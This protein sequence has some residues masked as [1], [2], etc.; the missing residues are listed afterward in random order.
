MP[1]MGR[2]HLRVLARDK[3]S[4]GIDSG[5]RRRETREG[6]K[7]RHESRPVV[8]SHSSLLDRACVISHLH[9]TIHPPSFGAGQEQR[10]YSS[11]R[12]ADYTSL[13]ASLGSKT[14]LPRI[15]FIRPNID[16]RPYSA[17]GAGGGGW[18]K[19]CRDPEPPAPVCQSRSQG[20][21]DCGLRMEDCGWRGRESWPGVKSG[22]G[23]LR[24]SP[25]RAA[26][27]RTPHRGGSWPNPIRRNCLPGH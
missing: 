9:K 27:H 11:S 3:I 12:R 22:T 15:A 6:T 19:S 25:F 24:V 13:R 20:V 8:Y 5:R 10:G 21:T 14:R 2:L 26:E 7:Q 16:I 17:E 18:P 23:A 4:G 1:V